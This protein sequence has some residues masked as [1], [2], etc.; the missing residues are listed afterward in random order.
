MKM[1]NRHWFYDT[2]CTECVGET[3]L[4]EIVRGN[5]TERV[6]A[7]C[8]RKGEHPIAC[9][10]DMLMAC[11]RRTIEREFYQPED[12]TR[13]D[14]E[15]EQHQPERFDTA[16]ILDELGLSDVGCGLRYRITCGLGERDWCRKV[17][18]K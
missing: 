4:K 7:L 3:A 1:A 2:I 16:G 8:G 6:C 12:E 14:D 15:V 17:P 9:D 5:V 13:P 18:L 11:L 10:F